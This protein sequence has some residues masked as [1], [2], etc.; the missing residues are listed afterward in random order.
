AIGTF[1]FAENGPDG[2]LVANIDGDSEARDLLGQRFG[3]RRIDIGDNDFGTFASEQ[4]AD[5]GADSGGAASDDDD[6][7]G[8]QVHF[9]AAPL[10]IVFDYASVVTDYHQGAQ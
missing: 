8:Q 6:F 2:L 1:A 9:S 7:S 4:A 5:C 3:Q 10:R